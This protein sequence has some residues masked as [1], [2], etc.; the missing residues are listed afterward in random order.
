MFII[1]AFAIMENIIVDFLENNDQ[2]M[3]N[4]QQI[5]FTQ[6]YMHLLLIN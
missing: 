3:N 4:L 1:P 5:N 6:N 2:I